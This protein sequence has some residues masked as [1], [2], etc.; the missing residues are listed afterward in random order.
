MRTVRKNK[1][2]LMYALYKGK[3]EPTIV[4]YRDG[5]PMF[6][7]DGNYIY[8]DIST[9]DILYDDPV[10]F[11]GNIAFKSGESEGMAYGVSIGDYDSTLIMKL[12]EL[13][14]DETSLIF[15]DSSPEYDDNGNLISSSADFTVI[16]VQPS[17]N[18]VTYLLKRV[19]KNA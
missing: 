13:P 1:Q 10:P 8:E 3:A 16:K 5:N 4:K 18:L 12:G 7:D 6:D 17:L 11:F 2:R 19:V 15:K 9:N 14:I